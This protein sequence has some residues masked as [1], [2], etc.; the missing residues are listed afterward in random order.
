[1]DLAEAEAILKAAGQQADDELDLLAIAGAFALFDLGDL[2]E[3]VPLDPYYRHVDEMAAA[4]RRA[5]PD[6]SASTDLSTHLDALRAVMVEGEGYNGDDQDYDALHNANILSV[7]ERRKGL[8]VALGLISM[9]LADRLGWDLA[10]LNFPG[11][12]LLKLSVGSERAV[13]DPFNSFS[14]RQPGD[15]RLL[16]KA[17]RGPEADFSPEHENVVSRRDVLLRLRN[18][19]KVRLLDAD[20]EEGALACVDQMCWLKPQ[21]PDLRREAAMLNIRL[22]KLRGAIEALEGVALVEDDPQAAIEAANMAREL[23]RKLN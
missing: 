12:F 4:I 15:L 21:D 2:D 6:T 14:E 23:H 1:M 19:V 16:I 8:P 5:L 11:H 10:G 17:H 18:N 22:S 20:D 7:M 9:A 13:I 3:P